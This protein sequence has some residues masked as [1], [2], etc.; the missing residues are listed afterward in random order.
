MLP[1]LFPSLQHVVPSVAEGHEL[2]LY[3]RRRVVAP[4]QQLLAQQHARREVV[5][6][7]VYFRLQRLVVVHQ[8]L[9]TTHIPKKK[10]LYHT[11]TEKNKGIGKKYN[12]EK[13]KPFLKKK[14]QFFGFPCCSTRDDLSIDVSITNVGLILTKLW[15][16]I[17]SG[18]G[19]TRQ[20]VISFLGVRTDRQTV[21]SFLGVRTDRHGFGILIWKHVGTHK[22]FQLETQN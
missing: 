3:L 6:P 5:F 1:A 17:F 13:C 22:K 4:R 21:I 19:Q 2:L 16:F 14:I 8:K 7:R 18:Y 11:L 20:M 9:H 12:F 10:K 15:W